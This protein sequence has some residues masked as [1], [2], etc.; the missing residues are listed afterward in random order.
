M[1]E[2]DSQWLA[3]RVVHLLGGCRAYNGFDPVLEFRPTQTSGRTAQSTI[4]G[5]Y[6]LFTDLENMDLGVVGADFNSGLREAKIFL[7]ADW[8]TYHASSGS[9]WACSN[10]IDRWAQIGNAGYRSK[11]I[12][13]WDIARRISHQLRVCSWRLRQISECYR[14]QLHAQT[15]SGRYKAGNWFEDEF[16]WLGYLSIQAFLVDACVLRDYLAEFYALY[17]CSEP[18]V[19]RGASPIT[20]ISGLLKKGV[21]STSVCA[22]P[23]TKE[24]KLATDE[25]GWLYLMGAY[26]D[27][28]VHCVPLAR[29]EVSLYALNTELHV[30][31]VG[32]LPSISLPLPANPAAIK[33]SRAKQEHLLTLQ[34]DLESFAQVSKGGVASADGLAYAYTCIDNLTKLANQLATYSPLPPEI[35]SLSDEDIIGDIKVTF[36]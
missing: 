7:P 19:A 32:V 35:V 3:S 10:E 6:T 33:K 29:A 9:N 17:A 20:S 31:G 28:V 16:T 12:A 15:I 25:D 8:R 23:V 11:N 13:L 21:L 36:N 34:D 26:R 2:R 30:R 5:Y 22:N 4:R 18:L 27:M 24:L 1:V 14:E